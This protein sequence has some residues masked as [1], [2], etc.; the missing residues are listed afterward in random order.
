[1]RRPGF[2]LLGI[3]ALAV[4]AGCSGHTTGASHLTEQP[5]GSYS[6]KL[7]A[8]G[9]CDEGSPS[10]PC[11]A[12][13]QWRAVGTNAWTKSRSIKIERKVSDR[14]RSLT[15]RALAPEAKYE[16]QV[17]GKEFA[18]ERVV[19]VGPDG[20]PATTQEFVTAGGSAAGGQTT[21]QV[22]EQASPAKGGPGTP[23]EGD[24]GTAPAASTNTTASGPGANASNSDSGD[25]GTSPVVPIV[26]AVGAIGLVLGGARWARRGPLPIPATPGSAALATA[27]A[28]EAR[29]GPATEA[30]AKT[31]TAEETTA[32]P[33]PSEPRP[34]LPGRPVRRPEPVTAEAGRAVG[35]G[36]VAG[37]AAGAAATPRR[38]GKARA[39]SEAAER[40]A[41]ARLAE[42]ER[43]GGAPAALEGPASARKNRLRAEKARPAEERRR[44]EGGPREPVPDVS[45]EEVRRAERRLE[46]VAARDDALAHELTRVEQRV[47]A[48]EGPTPGALERAA[49]LLEDVET[50]AADAEARAARA[51][52]LAE[53]KAEEIERARRLRE[54][55]DRIAEAER[56]ASEAETRARAT[57]E[58]AGEP[59]ELDAD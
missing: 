42:A 50:R 36:A 51:E 43:R 16:Y 14:S 53:V 11:T 7:N 35:G 19:C 54:T 27:E 28:P 17:C 13:M 31:V 55:L 8:V 29:P 9:S 47:A 30:A 39:T 45:P 3:G 6:A 57:I 23:P 44:L 40:E 56:R 33:E 48:T 59:P 12:Y 21:N 4:F 24:Q 46:E 10:T 2:L 15:A 32:A 37:A 20:T 18:V 52:R 1:M 5:D 38:E 58:R 22:G 41:L 25:G 49:A 26:I 34:A